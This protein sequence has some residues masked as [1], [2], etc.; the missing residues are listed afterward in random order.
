MANIGTEEYI[1]AQK[2]REAE[3]RPSA[4]SQ[5]QEPKRK[6]FIDLTPDLFCD[7]FYECQFC[8]LLLF[9]QLVAYLA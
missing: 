5:Y 8:P 4:A 3:S 1:V 7:L 9:C 6:H 2:L